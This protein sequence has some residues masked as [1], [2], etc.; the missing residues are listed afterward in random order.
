[1]YSEV[2]SNGIENSSQAHYSWTKSNE[3]TGNRVTDM[4][5]QG[6][7]VTSSE[8]THSSVSAQ[9]NLA[10]DLFLKQEAQSYYDIL[11]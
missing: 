5:T 11:H 9:L 7:H 6:Q 4:V 1:M 2:I 8:A 10:I 3:L